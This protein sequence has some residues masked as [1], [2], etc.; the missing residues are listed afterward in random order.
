LSITVKNVGCHLKKLQLTWYLVK[1]NVINKVYVVSCFPLE[2][3]Q[4]FSETFFI[5]C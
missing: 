5:R 2:T 1:D 4:P 3:E